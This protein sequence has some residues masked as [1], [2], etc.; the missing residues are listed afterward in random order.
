MTEMFLEIGLISL[1]TYML[2]CLVGIYIVKSNIEFL[3]KPLMKSDSDI[4]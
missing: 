3:K 1:M 2:K 4:F